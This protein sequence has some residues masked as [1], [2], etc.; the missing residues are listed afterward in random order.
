MVWLSNTM[1]KHIC[2]RGSVFLSILGKKYI[3]VI[4][5]ID[6]VLHSSKFA[7]NIHASVQNTDD[8][9]LEDV[10]LPVK[11]HMGASAHFSVAFPNLTAVLSHKGIGG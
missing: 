10:F 3:P 7:I 2:C 8:L 4:G 6:E 11:N 9:D 1:A 5:Q